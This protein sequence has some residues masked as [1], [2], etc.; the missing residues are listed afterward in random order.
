MSNLFLKAGRLAN[1]IGIHTGNQVPSHCGQPGVER[2][3][4]WPG[5]LLVAPHNTPGATAST[6]IIICADSYDP[7][8]WP[9]FDNQF[10]ILACWNEPLYTEQ[11]ADRVRTFPQLKFV[12]MTAPIFGRYAAHTGTV[13][14]QC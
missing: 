11:N 14:Y 3:C 12:R 10:K 4:W 2:R 8:L 5:P 13:R 9:N 1:V 6:G 7:R